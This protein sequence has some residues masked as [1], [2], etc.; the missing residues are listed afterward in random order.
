MKLFPYYLSIG[1]TYEL[2]WN[3][4]AWVAASYRDAETFRFEQDNY[5]MW[6]Q[7][8][9]DFKAVSSALAMAF[10]DKKGQKPEGYLEYPVPI[11]EREKEADKQR[12]I[13]K[14]LEF[15]RKGQLEQ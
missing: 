8:L 7:G 10:W 15:F 9:Y 5:K 2:F 4:P 1:C 6:L 11:T 13:Q 14:T 3:A 12:R